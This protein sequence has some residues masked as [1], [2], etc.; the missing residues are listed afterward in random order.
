MNWTFWQSEGRPD[1]WAVCDGP[2]PLN[3]AGYVIW[4]DGAWSTEGS[5][6]RFLDMESAAGTL[7][8]DPLPRD[9]N[10]YIISRDGEIRVVFTYPDVLKLHERDGWTKVSVCRK[11]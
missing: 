3:V 1:R 8:K 6:T 11:M 5:D 2:G 10:F 4:R 9:G 7:T